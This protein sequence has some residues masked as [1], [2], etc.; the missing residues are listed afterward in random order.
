MECRN[1][2][3]SF[4]S[5]RFF[6]AMTIVFCH[7]YLAYDDMVDGKI[8]ANALGFL[9]HGGFGVTHFFTLSGFLTFMNYENE[10][11]VLTFEKEVR[12]VWKRLSKFYFLHI[13]T[14]I[15]AMIY[16]R[17]DP[18]INRKII[19]NV[20]LIQA[21]FPYRNDS[22]NG[23]SWYLSSLFAIILVT[24]LLLHFNRRIKDSRFFNV[25]ICIACLVHS[26]YIGNIGSNKYY[27]HPA[28][29]TFQFVSGGVLYN[30][31]NKTNSKHCKSKWLII[32]S[33]F[34]EV[35]TYVCVF[36]I[37][38][39]LF[40][41]IAAILFI[42]TFYY[43]DILT[44]KLMIKLG[45]LTF[46][47]FLFHYPIVLEGSR[48]MRRNFPVSPFFIGIEIIILCVLPIMLAYIWDKIMIFIKCRK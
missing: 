21:W 39:V 7:I 38:S 22:I 3:S 11:D 24:P 47:I 27:F 37:Y 46:G 29:R 34:I 5:I 41:S 31:V 35:L 44:N 23:V 6:W 2:I 32:L 20:L 36:R 25:L 40:D 15:M 9:T 19:E 16:M 18:G 4:T 8:F 13:V 17:E 12:Y 30:I 28:F 33:L 45:G 14:M 42:V 10:F 48:L 26:F 43:N 1:R